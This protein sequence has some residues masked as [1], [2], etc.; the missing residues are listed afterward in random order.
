M[1]GCSG[2]SSDADTVIMGNYGGAEIEW[3]VLS[4]E[5]SRTLLITKYAIDAIPLNVEWVDTTWETSSLRKWLNSDFI[6]AAFSQ[7]E[8]DKIVPATL[9]NP[10]NPA[11]GTP[12]GSDTEDKVFLLSNEEAADY[13]ESDDLRKTSPTAFAE[14]RGGQ[15]HLNGM[16]Y[17]WTRTP[18]CEGRSVSFVHSAGYVNDRGRGV[19]DY[20]IGVR[21]AMWVN[22]E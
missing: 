22:L 1:T 6:N 17:W 11:Y 18:G 19:T 13:F 2:R 7:D 20:S 15:K 10:R 3:L 12:G 21:P 8:Q 14:S 9:T 5:D 16:I 4:R